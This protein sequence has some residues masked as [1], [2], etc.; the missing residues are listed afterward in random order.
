MSNKILVINTGP[1]DPTMASDFQ[2][3]M[4][5]DGLR[6]LNV[7]AYDE[8]CMNHL[9]SG[10]A[11]HDKMWGKGFFY[12]TT[13][14]TKRLPQD[15]LENIKWDYC[16]IPIHHTKHTDVTYHLRLLELLQEKIPLDR[17]IVIDGHDLPKYFYIWEEYAK[18]G[19]RYFKREKQGDFGIPIHFGIQ[20]EKISDPIAYSERKFDIAPLIPVNQNIDPSYMQTYKYN[21]E[22]SYFNMYRNSRFALTSKK[23][24]WDTLRHY[25]ILACGCLPWFVDIE[26]CPKDTLHDWPKDLLIEIKK[27]FKIQWNFVK[28]KEQSNNIWP[29]CGIVDMN[30]PGTI[31]ECDEEKFEYYVQECQSWLR[32]KGTTEAVARYMLENC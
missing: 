12:G 28:G 19:L 16:I 15:V 26:N 13:K 23:G 24:G 9:Y 14:S 6:R 29:H 4:V 3:D 22:K 30:N 5:V 18:H 20:E 1:D 2:F 27:E 10:Y 8:P 17:I 11:H 7:L 25:E 31:E 21:D 32:N